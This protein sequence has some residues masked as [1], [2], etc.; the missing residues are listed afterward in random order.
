MKYKPIT[1]RYQPGVILK[2]SSS[3]ARFA[4]DALIRREAVDLQPLLAAEIVKAQMR[5][6]RKFMLKL[7]DLKR[8]T[9]LLSE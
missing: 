2:P 8:I 9:G 6:D 5:G 1:F 3:A 7:L 4:L